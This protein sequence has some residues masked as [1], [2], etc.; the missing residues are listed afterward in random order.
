[1]G[2]ILEFIGGILGVFIAGFFWLLFLITID[3][4]RQKDDHPNRF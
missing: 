2:A 1:M 3:S 4:I